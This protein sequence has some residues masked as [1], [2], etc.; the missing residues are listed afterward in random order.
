MNIIFTHFL[1]N[2]MIE[3]VQGNLVQAFLKSEIDV[4]VHGCNCYCVM[5]AEIALQIKN[6][7]PSAY[8]KD[9]RTKLQYN[10]PK[11]KLGKI[12][13]DYI[14][15]KDG[16]LGLIINA[17]TQETYWDKKRKVSY[18]AISSSMKEV[19]KLCSDYNVKIGMP[20]IGCGLGGANWKIVSNLIN[21]VFEDRTIYVYYLNKIDYKI[22]VQS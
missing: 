13:Y 21:N 10:N 2:Y 11:D 17:Y 20:F 19:Y 12:S 3:Y 22:N 18:E 7:F 9:C 5:G 8:E 16:N 15:R 1:E 6:T 4:L 14:L